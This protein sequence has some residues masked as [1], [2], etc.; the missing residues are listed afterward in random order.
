[1]ATKFLKTYPDIR[2]QIL[3][4]MPHMHGP[5]D[6]GQGTRNENSSLFV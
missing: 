3:D 1:M 2:L 6:I 4:Q 5:I